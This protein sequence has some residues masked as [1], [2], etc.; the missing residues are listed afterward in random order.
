MS[1]FTSLTMA[2]MTC[3][4]SSSEML[5]VVVNLDGSYLINASDK[6]EAEL[7]GTCRSSEA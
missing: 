3:L 2:S 7:G 1:V 6:D 4:P 5:L